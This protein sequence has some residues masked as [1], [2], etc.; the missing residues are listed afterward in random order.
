M[1]AVEVIIGV[2]EL[3]IR[4]LII[5]KETVEIVKLKSVI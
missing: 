5:P 1:I 2:V 4:I 3:V